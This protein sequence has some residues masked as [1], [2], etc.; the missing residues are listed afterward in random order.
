MSSHPSDRRRPPSW[1]IT[2][3]KATDT[4]LGLLKTGKEADT[5]LVER[6]LGERSHLLARKL[7][8]SVE[9]RQFRNDAAYRAGRRTGNRRDDLAMAK[10]SRAGMRMR[11]ESW[12]LREFQV[13]RRLWQ[14][15]APVPYPVTCE[16]PEVLMEFIGSEKEAAPRLVEASRM[17]RLEDSDRWRQCVGLLRLMVRNGVVHA[18]LSPYNLLV[19]HRRL[20]APR[21]S[22]GGGPG[23]QRPGPGP[24]AVAARRQEPLRLL[25]GPRGPC[26]PRRAVR[27][28][29]LGHPLADTSLK[30]SARGPR[31]ASRRPAPPGRL[32]SPP[33]HALMRGCSLPAR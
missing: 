29:D 21:L 17:R 22:A 4:E 24:G 28:P 7:Y 32:P 3:P 13:L 9:H 6:R 2:D 14:A 26:G 18:D 16:G 20:I 31:A 15:G 11:A 12:A 30:G 23:A 33:P 19:W 10:G 25:C 5:R 27:G 1:L 8:R